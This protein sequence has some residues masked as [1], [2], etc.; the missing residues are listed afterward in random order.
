M[1]P[2]VA[3]LKTSVP[4]LSPVPSARSTEG[5][6][7]QLPDWA[8]RVWKEEA[9]RMEAGPVGNEASWTQKVLCSPSDPGTG[10]QGIK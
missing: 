1:L 2:F 7:R 5:R 9:A 10:P 3:D 8:G 4:S 6:G